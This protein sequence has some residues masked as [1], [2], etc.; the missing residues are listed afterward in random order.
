MKI[1]VFILLIITIISFVLFT[2]DK[3]REQYFSTLSAY[4]PRIAEDQA[5]GNLCNY[6]VEIDNPEAKL[7]TIP[8]SDMNKCMKESIIMEETQRKMDCKDKIEDRYA[9]DN[10]IP[11]TI[12]VE[13]GSG[14]PCSVSLSPTKSLYILNKR[15]FTYSVNK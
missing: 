13:L 8:E 7:E 14:F 15:I 9:F 1:L 11:R 10:N 6:P 4:L 5:N 12:I 2:S 3:D